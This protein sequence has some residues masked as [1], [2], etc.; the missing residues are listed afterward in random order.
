MSVRGATLGLVAL[1]LSAGLVATAPTFARSGSN[2]LLWATVNVCD[3]KE[4][5]DA[6]GIRGSMPGTMKG[7]EVMF[8]RFRAQYLS[9]ED[10][11]WHNVSG[12]ADS[13]YLEVGRANVKARQKGRY[14]KVEPRNDS[15]VLRGVVTFQWRRQGKV[16]RRAQRRTRKGH[17]S[18]AGADP[19]GYS[20]TTCT[21]KR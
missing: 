2:P 16:L 1:T 11:K 20:A 6:I 7:R 3:T 15:V 4:H 17:T 19:A 18:K 14:I 8:M 5:P 10:D 12:E 13:G 9:V 21:I